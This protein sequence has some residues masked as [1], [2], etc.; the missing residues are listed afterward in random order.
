M[1]KFL[2]FPSPKIK[3][4]KEAIS[5]LEDVQNFLESRNCPED[6]TM[7]AMLIDNLATQRASSAKETSLFNYFKPQYI[8]VCIPYNTLIYPAKYNHRSYSATSI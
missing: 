7:A 5:A 8:V 3:S 6:A 4:F 2:R 1:T